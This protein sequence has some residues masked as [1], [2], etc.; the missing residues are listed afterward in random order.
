LYGSRPSSVIAS[1]LPASAGSNRRYAL[2]QRDQGLAVVNVSAGYPD[3]DGQTGP[4]GDQMDLRPVLA[5]VHRI[6]ACRVPLF[7]ARMYTESIAHLD[8]SRSPRE[9]SSSRTRRWSLAHTLA[10]TRRTG[11]EPSHR[12]V[13]TTRREAAAT[14]I[15]KSL[16]TRSRPAPPDRHADADHRPV[17]AKAPRAPPA[18]TVPTTHPAPAAARSKPRPTDQRSK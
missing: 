18:G 3:G 2:H 14:C 16:R 13:R 8:Q 6:R 17:V 15:R 12:K 5:P 11:G 10:F 4:L 9:P 7:R 1:V